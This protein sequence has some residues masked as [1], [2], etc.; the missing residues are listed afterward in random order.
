MKL[1]NFYRKFDQLP[2]DERFNMFE[3]PVE[4]TSLFVIFQRLTQVRAQKKFFEEQEIHL[5][6]LA[7]IGFEKLN[8][9]DGNSKRT[10]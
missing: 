7:D 1:H 9:E 6:N 5:L 3:T 8:N 10:Q 2:R 4:P